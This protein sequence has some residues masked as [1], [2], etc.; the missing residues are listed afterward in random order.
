VRLTRAGEY[1][2][3]GM[4]YLALQPAD[5]LVQIADIAGRQGVSPGFLAKIFQELSRAGLVESHRGAGGGVSLGLPADQVTLRMI[6]EAVEGPIALNN[7]LLQEDGCPK[8]KECGLAVTWRE[9]Q[10]ALTGVLERTT[11]ADLA[12]REKLRQGV[13][14]GQ[15][16]AQGEQ[17]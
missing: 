2:I 1:A 8:A 16:E 3:K 14:G 10:G 7:C 6:I 12:G 4:V 15:P 9:A 17:R 5:G 13:Q 11:L